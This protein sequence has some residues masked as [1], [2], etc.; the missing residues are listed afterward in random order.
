MQ[1]L[2]GVQREDWEEIEFGKG[3]EGIQRNKASVHTSHPTLSCLSCIS[4][5]EQCSDNP[6]CLIIGDGEV[7]VSSG[8]A[9][10]GLPM[11]SWG[12]R[13]SRDNPLRDPFV[14]VS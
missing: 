10:I 1:G 2:A 14:L 11:Y 13:S 12:G 5:H 8:R 7:C 3:G 9:R 4:I 6:S